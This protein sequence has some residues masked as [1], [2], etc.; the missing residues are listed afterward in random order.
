MNSVTPAGSTGVSSPVIKTLAI[1]FSWIFHPLLLGLYMAVYVIY[2]DPDYFIG[3]SKG[4]KTQTLYI[5]IINS[6]FFPLIAVFL[7]KALG[8]VQS[9]Y[10][11]TQKERIVLYAIT[12]IFF[13]WTFYVFR[14]K[15]GIPA[16]MAQL[17][18]GI[19]LSVIIDFVANIYFKISMHA[20]GA[21]GLV[22]LFTVILYTSSGFVS[23]P[24]AIAVFVAG[25]TC[26]SRLITSDHRMTDMVMGLTAGF[27]S[28][29][30]AAWFLN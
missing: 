26:T 8:F 21:G 24:L 10:L 3:L 7:C 29:W 23:I 1:F 6:I 11:K 17:S 30:L 2:I 5:Y 25:L 4:A 12:M 19:F 27:A 15:P 20:T 13:F 16:I 9:I 18:L 22:G 14:N 28:Q